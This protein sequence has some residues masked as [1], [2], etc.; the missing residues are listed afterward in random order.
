MGLAHRPPSLPAEVALLPPG[1]GAGR[2][3]L[4]GALVVLEVLALPLPFCPCPTVTSQQPLLA[5]GKAEF[6]QRALGTSHNQD[7]YSYY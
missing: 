3:R 2:S 1:Y 6:G 4:C 7:Y 5:L